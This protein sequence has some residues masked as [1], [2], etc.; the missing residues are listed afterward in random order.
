MEYMVGQECCSAE[1]Y[2]KQE[3]KCTDDR[4]RI[5]MPLAGIKNYSTL[6]ISEEQVS[7]N[8]SIECLACSSDIL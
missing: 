4:K 5:T 3:N 6:K 1:I 7:F 8:F 2:D